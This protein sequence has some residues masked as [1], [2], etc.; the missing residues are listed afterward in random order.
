M[1]LP[2]PSLVAFWR[3]KPL[4]QYRSVWYCNRP[5]STLFPRSPDPAK[6]RRFRVGSVR[7]PRPASSRNVRLGQAEGQGSRRT[8]L[9]KLPVDCD[10]GLAH[11]GTASAHWGLMALDLCKNQQDSQTAGYRHVRLLFANCASTRLTKVYPVR[12]W[13]GLQQHG[14]GCT[15]VTI[16]LTVTPI[17]TQFTIRREQ[18]VWGLCCAIASAL[19]L[20]CT[21]TRCCQGDETWT[22]C[23]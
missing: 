20:A 13:P 2:E 1:H 6:G 14:A 9:D 19:L 21:C 8:H 22:P 23:V 11:G 5:Y 4:Q 7:F 12:T 18:A 16:A 15:A 10:L 17:L 3:C